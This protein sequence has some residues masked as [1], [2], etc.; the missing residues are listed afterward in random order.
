M[1]SFI[2]FSLWFFAPAGLAN[3]AAFVSGK[4]GF[5]KKLNYPVDCHLKVGGKRILGDHKTVRGFLSAIV[6]GIIACFVEIVCYSN[7]F[8]IR[9]LIPVDYYTVNPIILGGLLGL[10]A[11]VGDSVKSF[12]KRR[13]NI[14]PGKSWF[15]FDQIDYIIGGIVFSA[16]YIH[17]SFGEY[18][19][20]FIV[21][22]LLHPI[23]TSIGYLLKIRHMPI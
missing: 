3:M 8:S 23:T 19:L 15:P 1:F 22:F 12:F 11:L 7:F 4:I 10:G 14:E 16:F 9:E 2:F 17:L 21:W 18:V 5:L 20:L 6:V 13:V